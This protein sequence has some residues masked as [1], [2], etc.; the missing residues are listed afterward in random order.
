[1]RI[2]PIILSSLVLAGAAYADP[3]P[4]D[5]HG[6]VDIVTRK[7]TPTLR[8]QFYGQP[9]AQPATCPVHMVTGRASAW[10]WSL[11]ALALILAAV[12]GV[13]VWQ[14]VPLL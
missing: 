13:L 11:V 7:P 2:A 6:S 12:A 3:K 9:M 10:V 14:G 1:M 4:S 5:S 8:D